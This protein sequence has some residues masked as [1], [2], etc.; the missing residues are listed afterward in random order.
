MIELYFFIFL[1]MVAPNVGSYTQVRIAGPEYS[2]SSPEAARAESKIS[3]A[4]DAHRKP[5]RVLGAALDGSLKLPT[6]L[7][8]YKRVKR[9]FLPRPVSNILY[10][11]ET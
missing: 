3:E 9:I 8:F 5:P 11:V 10:K 6:A 4:K 7:D 1:Y 2:G